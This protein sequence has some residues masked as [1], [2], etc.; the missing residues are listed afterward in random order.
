MGISISGSNSISGLGGNDTD[1]DKV[2]TQLKQIEKTQ[3]NR[4][5]A[6]KS[7]WKLRYDGF[8][9]IIEQIQAASSML[10][11][12]S[13]RNNFVSKLVNSS[14]DNI[15][16][17]VANAS[18]QDVQ[19]TVKVNQVA[20]N[21]IWANTGHV[22]ESK[23]DIINTTGENQYFSYTYAGKRHDFK[24]PPNTT[25]DSF[26]S[27]VNNSSENPGIKVS[28][29]QTGSGYVFQVAGKDT[30]AANDLIIHDSK[31]VGM[32]ASGSTSTWQ[33]NAALDLDQS[34]TAPT[35]YVFDLVLANGTKK[36]VTVSG[37]KSPEDLCVALENAAGKGVITAS[38]DENGTL[39][40]SGVQSISRRTNKDEAYVPASTQVTLSGEL[41]NNKG[42][43]VKLNA[44]GGL[45][46]G[47]GDDDLIS[48]TME[49]EDGTTR[50]FEIKAGATKRDLLVQMAQATQEGSSLDIG[51][52][53]ASWGTN[54]SGVTGL[55]FEAQNG[56]TLNDAALKTKIT[57]AKG[58]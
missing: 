55:T 9:Q 41:K 14:N 28:L 29:I 22:F 25:L 53:G 7:D 4:L 36:T 48:F 50:T 34:M 13:D 51:L 20:S 45:A 15:L 56:A 42:E 24:V 33:T 58:V 54:L 46:E 19:H 38:V 1:F 17:A 30:G 57:D 12:L 26:V 31:L 32:D 37:D 47:L 8:T 52:M 35:K 44:A 27:M 49:M 18:A 3:L 2:L 43:Y 23:T 16:T 5:E 6:W 39:T 11:Q 10:S 40:V 21:A